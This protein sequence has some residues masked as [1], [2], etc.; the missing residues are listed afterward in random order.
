MS[1]LT[2]KELT[3][4]IVVLAKAE[5]IT[6][7]AL[8]ELSRELLAA[9]VDNGDVSLINQV[10]GS[11]KINKKDTAQ[12][13]LTPMNF[14]TAVSYFR[15]FIP[16]SSNWEDVKEYCLEGKGNRAALEFSKGSKNAAKRIIA[17]NEGCDSVGEVIA[18]WLKDEANDI[19]SW[20]G[21][22]KMSDPNK[23]YCAMLQKALVNAMDEEKG[24]MSV[25]QVIDALLESEAEVSASDLILALTDIAANDQQ[26]A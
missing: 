23:D 26:A 4:K 18:E 2:N 9:Y 12:F 10:L 14:R 17:A 11:T 3:A 16:H 21:N 7:K 15:A 19:W 8:S 13:T 24:G 1:V 22:I 20:S 5:R 25:T 6:K